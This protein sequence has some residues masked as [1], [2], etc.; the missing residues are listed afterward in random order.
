MLIFSGIYKNAK[1]NPHKICMSFG[2]NR[3]VYREF[4]HCI[5]QRAEYLAIRYSKCEKVIIKNINPI[6]T[7]INFLACSRAGLAAVPINFKI[8][9]SKIDSIVRKINP[10]CI[11]DDKFIFETQ[12]VGQEGRLPLI[13]DSDIFL[14]A[15]SSGT[16]GHNKVIW[17]DH[18]S[19][20]SAFKYQNQVFHISCRDILFLV[21]SLSY[22]ANL[23]SAMHILNEGGSIVFSSS[24]Y[25]GTW[26]REICKNNV[27]SI[28][29]VPAHYRILLKELKTELRN[30]KSILSAGDKIDSDTVNM[31]KSKFP[32]AYVCEYY[33]AS[34]LG[35][36]AYMDFRNNK[37]VNSVGKAFPQVKLWIQDD[38]VWV[39]S[40]YIAPDFRP[41]ATVGDVGKINS[42]GNL[43]ILGRKNNTINKGGIKILPYNIEKILDNN[44]KILKSVVFGIKDSLKGEEICAAIVP[45][46]NNITVKEIREYCR[47]NLE[48]YLQ[49]KKIKIVQH[50]KLN[51]SGKIDYR[52]LMK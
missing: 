12:L 37:N 26:I 6:N 28:F 44:P 8:T 16:T 48:S 51:S 9:Q 50:L 33:G 46:T 31:L 3:I 47:I 14:G 10:C 38:V 20:T 27:T 24:I 15:L 42:K 30:V 29:M 52:N 34:E 1:E 13:E 36:V 41:R 43:Y 39:E 22:T 25:P 32:D 7:I 45:K 21:G 4:V 17:R 19:W 23:N 18:K 40:P 5:D 35:H 2:N 11:I 49:P